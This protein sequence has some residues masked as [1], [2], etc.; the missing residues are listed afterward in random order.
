MAQIEFLEAEERMDSNYLELGLSKSGIFT[1]FYTNMWPFEWKKWWQFIG[2]GVPDVCGKTP[3]NR[4]QGCTHRIVY[5][6]DLVVHPG[7]S[8]LSPAMSRF[9]GR[10]EACRDTGD[11]GVRQAT[12]SGWERDNRYGMIWMSPNMRTPSPIYGNCHEYLMDKKMIINP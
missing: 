5:T 6:L 2:M 8:P 12:F 3:I 7:G 4:L 11:S 9:L 1:P 10:K